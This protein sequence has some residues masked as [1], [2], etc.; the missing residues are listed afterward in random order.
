MLT[1]KK[2]SGARYAETPEEA[3]DFFDRFFAYV[4]Q[5]DFLTGRNG[6]WRGCTLAWL[7]DATNFAKVIEGTYNHEEERAAA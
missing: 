4:A 1:A 2:P 3:I 7:M 6:K 5:S